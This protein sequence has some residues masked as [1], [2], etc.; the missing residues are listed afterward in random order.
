MVG[1]EP[2]F[3]RGN[4]VQ[5]RGL[6]NR[7]T[8][9]KFS[10]KN[11]GATVL[12][13]EKALRLRPKER[14][15]VMLS[16]KEAEITMA[17]QAFDATNLSVAT[18]R[19]GMLVLACV[20]RIAKAHI[21]LLLPGCISGIV[22][23]SMIS[24]AYSLRL[25][26]MINTGSTNCPTLN[27]LYRVGDLVYVTLLSK[28]S[29]RLTF[30][31][32]P[33]DLHK[34]YVT[35][36]L[37]P[38]LVLSA[39]IVRKEDH[40]YSMDIGVRNVRGF[41][42]DESLGQNR[43]DVGRNLVCSIESVSRLDSNPTVLLKAF[44]PEAP[45]VLNME[46][47]DMETIVPGCRM[48]FTVGEQVDHGL[49]GMLFE[50][51]VPAY[52]NENM[53]TKPTSRPDEYSMFKKIPATLLYV[54]PVTKQVFVSLKPYSKNRVEMNVNNGPG[55]IIEKAYVKAVKD[56]GVWFQFGNKC[57]ALLRWKTIMGET[58]GN[59][60]KSVVMEKFQVG[61]TCK[62]AIMH[63]NPLEDTY[64]V[65]NKSTFFDE[66]IRSSEDIVIGNLY[67]AHV[68]K[69][70]PGGAF[71]S[72]GYARGS[73]VKTYYD[74][75]HPVKV[76]DKV[77]V[78]AVMR[79]LDSPFVKFTNHPAL[80]DEKASILHDWDQLDATRNDQSFHGVIFKQK[81][82]T[83]FVRFFNDIVGVIQ[84]PRAIAN[85]NITLMARLNVNTVH[86]FTVLGFDKATK[87]LELQPVS[88]AEKIQSASRLVKARISC[89][90]AA[91]VDILT[92][93]G[94]NGTIP[95]ECLSEFG[96]HN[97][98]YMR[99]LREGQSVMAIQT[100]PDTYSMRLI[101]YFRTHPR[102]IESVQRGALL[103]GSCTNV[104]GVLY[105]TPL[106]TNFSKQIEV[107]TKE[108]RGTVQDGSIMMMRV[109]NVK[110]SPNS[111]YDLDVSTALLDVCENGTKDV[112]NF[113]AEYLKDVKKLIKRYQV[114][115]FGF[116]NY[117]LGDLVNCVVESIVP[118]S[119]QV[120]VEVHS[121]RKK[122][123]NV[124]KG[125]ATAIL[126]SHPA[127]SY[128]VGQKVPGRVVWIDVERKLL[129]VCLDQPLVKSI[130]PNSSLTGRK[131][132]PD[133]QSCWVLYANNY[134]QVCCLQANPPNPLVIVPVKYHYNDLMEK[135]NN[136][137]KSVTVRL[138]RN[139]DDMIFGINSKEMKLYEN[140]K[141]DRD[142]EG[143]LEGMTNQN[144][145]EDANS[146][147]EIMD[148]ND[149]DNDNSNEEPLN[150]WRV[151]TPV[152]M[153]T[154]NGKKKKN[155]STS[156][157]SKKGQGE[158][159]LKRMIAVEAKES[160]SQ[161]QL[162]LKKKAPLKEDPETATA[163]KR[164]KKT[165]LKK[166]KKSIVELHSNGANAKK[167]N[168]KK[169]KM[170]L[171]LEQLDG[172]CDFYLHQLDGTEDI[173]PSSN[174][175]MGARKR[176]HTTE[177]NGLP[178]AVNFWDSTPVYKRTVS[179]SSDDETHSSDDE[180]CETVGKM[181]I[182]AKERFEAMKKEE[183]RLR[184]IEDELANPSAD[185]HT[186]DQFDR[187]V[188]AQ[189]NNSMLWI[190]YMAFHMESA[191]LD[192]ARAVGRKAL[193]AIHFREETDRLNVWMALLNLEIRYET[194]DSFKEV[195]Q[196]AVQYNDAFK[197]YSRAV[198]ILI[199]CQK[200]AE[201]QEM[202]EL[203][204]KKFRKQ[205]DMWF[206][207]AD[208][209]YR[210][211]Q[212]SKVKPLL[213][214]ALKSLPAREHI[215]MIVKFAFLH[216]RNENRD[217]AHLLFEQILTSYPKRTDIWSQYIDM[218]V[219]DNL[220]GN[221]RQI[222]ERA[223]MQRLPM[224]NMKTLYTKYVNFEEKHGDRDSVRRVK[225]MATDYVQAQLNNAGIN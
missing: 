157:L 147:Y 141:D 121:K 156:D 87:Q 208:A 8:K 176:K 187:L 174:N 11:Y 17:Q 51:M 46:D 54:M 40:G 100:N 125:I 135:V 109:L 172:A 200:H 73:L 155:G 211:G 122:S 93:D 202:L 49:R 130:L 19:E 103:K 88:T 127:T 45:W 131:Y 168:L 64:I 67:T 48:M 95:S 13:E 149:D 129:H 124:T 107:K 117:N 134:V 20:K 23:I 119:N 104:N 133:A 224:K 151:R 166:D 63:Y 160:V 198:D 21:E 77:L 144:A 126:P 146:S 223:I 190:R 179:D 2:A 55:T 18:M 177:G 210:I 10:P 191:E 39:T 221:A 186:P 145:E 201:V 171:V 44:D 197:V 110:K 170:P 7:V 102:Q 199:D 138:V 188:L 123:K 33:N 142:G 89:V 192:K 57:R 178:G 80:V 173:T 203:L 38:G 153:S 193:K 53:L 76:H 92:N 183:E 152:T 217:E 185:P 97:S 90:H 86:K 136:T 36:Q 5:K 35:S 219:K 206:L 4:K 196:E 83:V 154:S 113:T 94:Q 27:D 98:L 41:L 101:S 207:V 204:L 161:M 180:Q 205:N 143:Q 216:N 132:T 60:D 31:L 30:S 150:G 218:L 215:G 106:L 56:A 220:V 165:I 15:E 84:K 167:S 115:K 69:T 140:M 209:W 195:L 212:G 128:T 181:R 22:P 66:E 194:V 58:A 108:N 1:V 225:Q 91:G 85:Q 158:P 74:H 43:D 139:L 164:T 114:E 71:V 75:E 3:P 34:S 111:R 9:R 112:F 59:V 72:V 159:K 62:L 70:I 14:R 28:E 42:S 182:T 214:Q 120:T 163:A 78:R 222:L 148:Y 137:S 184:K 116:A 12:P 162:P 37:V 189:P 175:K 32:K 50:D 24:D 68:L 6:T 47:A 96:E 82:D 61:M 118:S 169:K 16:E 213:S 65:S 79:E 105:I 81:T 26:D 29:S 25:K 52:V 99:L